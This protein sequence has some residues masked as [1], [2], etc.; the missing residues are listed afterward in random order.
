MVQKILI[1]IIIALFIPIGIH[2]KNNPT[3]KIPFPYSLPAYK[4]QDI[5]API[6]IVGDRMANKLYNFKDEIVNTISVNLSKPIAL[7]SMAYSTEGLHR[8]LQRLKS[9]KKFPKV[10]IYT[11]ASQEEWEYRFITNESSIILKNFK[12]Y[13]DPK[14]QTLLVLFPVLS[15]FIFQKIKKIELPYEV[16]LDPNEYSEFE[17]FKR[18][19][20]HYKLF[21]HE[22]NELIK[23]AR[24]KNSILIMMTTPINPNVKPKKVCNKSVNPDV[25]KKLREVIK[26]VKQKDFKS[27]YERAKILHY[28]AMGNARVQYIYSRIARKLGKKEEAKYALNLSSSYDCK[29]WRT[30]GV[31][32]TLIRKAAQNEDVFLHDFDNYIAANWDKNITFF[33]EVYPQSIFYERTARALG[34]LIKKLL[35]L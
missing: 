28:L 11:G 31:Y 20:V 10:I 25:T 5:T 23:L 26:L 21:K 15:K 14:L 29:R 19:E 17:L 33:D 9:L 3:Q 2:L 12:N 30:N 35:N 32:N 16:I 27:A 13:E 22:L 18:I 6:V 1:L 24:E 8:T 4:N 7:Q 34:K